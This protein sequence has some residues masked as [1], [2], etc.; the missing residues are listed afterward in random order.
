MKK[1]TK[2]ILFWTPRIL[3][4]SFIVLISMFA[5]DVFGENR[6]F[7]NTTLALLIH[8]IPTGILLLILALTWRWEWVGALLFPALGAFYIIAFWGRFHWSV[9]LILSGSLFFLGALFLLGWIYR[10]ELRAKT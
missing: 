9:Y 10:S 1:P 8:L 6:G 3:C 4:L 7:W 2:R 5:L